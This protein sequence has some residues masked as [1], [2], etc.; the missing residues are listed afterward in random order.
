MVSHQAVEI[1]VPPGM[2]LVKS[3]VLMLAQ[4]ET[5]NVNANEAALVA[6]DVLR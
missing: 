6:F 1:H 4:Y 3:M 2:N 5:L